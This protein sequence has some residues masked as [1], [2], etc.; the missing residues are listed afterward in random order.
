MIRAEYDF[1]LPVPPQEAFAVLSDPERDPEWQSAC[2]ETRLLNGA[3]RTGCRYAITFQMIGRRLPFTVEITA[4]EP[5]RRS[6]FQVLEGPFR[7]VGT[8][9]YSERP[10]GGTGVHWT[11]EVEPGDYFGIMP[12]SLLG[13]VLVNQVKKD[14]GKLAQRLAGAAS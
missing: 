13:K 2:L 12:K 4:Y 5:G 8:Y 7:Y 14:S 3:A 10:G 6:S 1:T 11:F 9:D